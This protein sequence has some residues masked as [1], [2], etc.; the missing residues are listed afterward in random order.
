MRPYEC[1]DEPMNAY[2]NWLDGNYLKEVSSIQNCLARS[3]SLE[4][5][6]E[7][8]SN[9][10]LWPFPIA[11]RH[12]QTDDK[13]AETRRGSELLTM[14]YLFHTK[15]LLPVNTNIYSIFLLHFFCF[16]VFCLVS[17]VFFCFKMNCSFH[18]ETFI[19]T[20]EWLVNCFVFVF[21]FVLGIWFIQRQSTSNW[22]DLLIKSEP[23][24][25]L[26]SSALFWHSVGSI[27]S[28]LTN[29]RH[30]EWN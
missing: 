22:L 26:W 11:H 29:G 18:F 8:R 7:W 1:D 20:I 25:W 19:W 21:V 10:A 28:F 14:T 4:E 27:F 16:F 3:E 13:T 24:I 6:S 2:M 15:D 12:T 23:L 5:P 30:S 17:F 9:F